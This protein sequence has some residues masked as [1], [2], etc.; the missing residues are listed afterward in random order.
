MDRENVALEIYREGKRISLDDLINVWELATMKDLTTKKLKKIGDHYARKNKPHKD[1]MNNPQWHKYLRG[2]YKV[3]DELDEG[4]GSKSMGDWYW[5]T[6]NPPEDDICKLQLAVDKFTA[7]KGNWNHTA[8]WAYEQRSSDEDWKGFH[9]HILFNRKVASQKTAPSVIKDALWKD[10]QE[11]GIFPVYVPGTKLPFKGS[12]AGDAAI[13]CRA[14]KEGTHGRVYS[15]LNGE[16]IDAHKEKPSQQNVKW[17]ESLGLE[18]LYGN[19]ELFEGETE[20]LFSTDESEDQ[21]EDEPEER[22]AEAARRAAFDLQEELAQDTQ[23]EENPWDRA[24]RQGR[25]RERTV[26]PYGYYIENSD[27][28]ESSCSDSGHLPIDY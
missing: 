8:V 1:Y 5:V 2:L 11:F 20:L 25:L 6:I 17:R 24:T 18:Q 7:R 28:G 10:T 26:S 27:G 4:Q 16:K 19:A 21:S 12:K 15:Y 23:P 13:H 14:V 22:D 9:V 3:S